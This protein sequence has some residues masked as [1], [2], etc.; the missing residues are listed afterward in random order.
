MYSHG[1]TQQVLIRDRADD[2]LDAVQIRM[3][4]CVNSGGPGISRKS[5]S[6]QHAA[7]YHLCAGGQRVRAK[8]ALHAGLALGLTE[9]SVVAIAATVELLHN[10]SLIHDDIQDYEDVRRGQK[11]VWKSYGINTAICTGDLLLSAAY[12]ALSKIEN[13]HVLPVMISLLHTRTASAIDGQCADLTA[14]ANLE[15]STPEAVARYEQIAAAKSGALLRLPI[16][17]ALLAADHSRY[18]PDA[19]QAVE[20]FAIG[21]QIV[22]D[23]NDIQSDTG[24]GSAREN[25]NIITIYKANGIASQAIAKATALG[26]HHLGLAIESAARLPL[27]AGAL[28]TTYSHGLGK[29]LADK[30]RGTTV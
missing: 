3:L 10:A 5:A 28:L 20:A 9:N 19:K 29:H 1:S 22:D 21:Y 2:L 13:S 8:L 16:E 15:K 30:T 23:L 6:A 11:A 27:G 18:L 7:A 12:A 25:F 24:R 4:E 14:H 17:L 26:N